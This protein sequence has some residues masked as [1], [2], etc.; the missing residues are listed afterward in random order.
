MTKYITYEQADRTQLQQI[1]AGLDD[2]VIIID[3]DQSISWANK[4]ALKMHGVAM[5]ADLGST[6]DQYRGRFELRY[7]NNHKVAEGSYPIDRVIAGEAFDEVVVEVGAPG[8]PARWTH[9]LRSL[10]LSRPDGKPDC[11]VLVINDE[12]ARFSAEERF[13]ATFAANPAPAII[14]RLDDLRYVKVN[15]GFVEM[16][17]HMRNNLIG[18][19][20]YEIDVLEGADRKDEAIERLNQGRTIP[21]MEATIRLAGGGTKLVIVAGQPIDMGE[22]PCMLFTFADLEPRR[23]SEEGLRHSEERFSKAFRLAPGPMAL[24]TL[25]DCRTLDVNRAFTAVTGYEPEEV[26]GRTEAELQLWGSNETRRKIHADL[27]DHGHVHSLEL[28][29]RTKSGDTVDYLFSAETL[30]LHGKPCV[31]SVMQDIT[32]RKRS[33]ED[34]LAAI[35]AVMQDTSWF[36]Q[37]I[38]EKLAN[39][40]RTGK[41]TPE[42]PEVADLS[43]RERDVMSHLAQGKTDPEIALALGL[44]PVT[45]RNHVMASYAK[46]GVNRRAAA[47]IWARERG[48]DGEPRTTLKKKAKRFALGKR[49]QEAG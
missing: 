37:K 33:Q 39:L 27:R 35:E 44:S 13:E 12:T 45:V 31:L 7:R 9:R 34:L 19:S 5:L 14:C 49:T 23:L 16:T 22:Q 4:A 8:E 21:Q 1:I 42:L 48:L 26:L 18:R 15:E 11:L 30:P 40:T 24:S 25:E 36:S 3:P 6:V 41:G 28:Q 10:V 29:L 32:A 20:V 2:G 46:I 43:P 47:V 38:V 17:G